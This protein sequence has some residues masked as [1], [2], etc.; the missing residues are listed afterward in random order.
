[1][2][3]SLSFESYPNPP[4]LKRTI[5]RVNP[6]ADNAKERIRRNQS[7]R[8][9]TSENGDKGGSDNYNHF[10]ETKSCTKDKQLTGTEHE[11]K[12]EKEDR[13]NAHRTAHSIIEKNR[14]LKMNKQFELLK[15]LVPAFNNKISS[16]TSAADSSSE[17][18][19]FK[20]TIL[21]ATVEYIV[22]LHDLIK[23]MEKSRNGSAV[24]FDS[25]DNYQTAPSISNLLNKS[26]VTCSN[27]TTISDSPQGGLSNSRSTNVNLLSSSSSSL[28][29]SVFSSCTESET[30]HDLVRVISKQQP[31]INKCN[32]D[33]SI[34][35]SIAKPTLT[36][37]KSF[38]FIDMTQLQDS[39]KPR[40]KITTT[41][42]IDDHRNVPRPLQFIFPIVNN[43]NKRHKSTSTQPVVANVSSNSEFPIKPKCSTVSNSL[44]S[45]Q[46]LSRSDSTFPLQVP[47]ILPPIQSPP[48]SQSFTKLQS[49]AT[50]LSHYKFQNLT[51]DPRLKS[52]QN[53]SESNHDHLHDISKMNRN[54]MILRG[55]RSRS[56]SMDIVTTKYPDYNNVYTMTSTSP[57]ENL[58]NV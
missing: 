26:G 30:N 10:T 36:H 24:V 2:S 3:K 58:K 27:N 47:R 14:R 5:I 42:T 19:V 35:R 39:S 49:S 16:S 43:Q 44:P 57:K 55:S 12:K 31:I 56:L 51:I 52:I 21:E 25:P 1:M 41:A 50:D 48:R 53:S 34:S 20:L 13:R 45:I 15:Q 38:S 7:K 6:A 32:Q 28:V 54:D 17:S 22:Y 18:G 33:L 46:F 29:S 9:R 8:R 23:T 37:E 40:A 4:P 11:K